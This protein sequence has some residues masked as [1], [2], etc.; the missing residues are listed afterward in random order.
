MSDP[1]E[2]MSWMEEPC[3]CGDVYSH[4]DGGDSQC[5]YCS[6]AMRMREEWSRLS[7]EGKLKDAV[8]AATRKLMQRSEYSEHW[9]RDWQ[10]VRSALADLVSEGLPQND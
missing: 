1:D 5:R 4:P 6:G 2:Y 3:N 10:N 9:E 7:C 8:I